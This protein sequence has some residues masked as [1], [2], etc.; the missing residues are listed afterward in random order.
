MI[1]IIFCHPWHGSFNYAMLKAIIEK[2]EYEKREYQLI[3]L[4]ADGFN[5][6]MNS[7]DLR[8][9]SRGESPDPLVNKYIAM[10]QNTDEIIFMF[11]IWWGMIPAI[12]KGFF[13]RVLLKGSSFSHSSAGEMVPKLDIS[14]CLL[15]STSQG[16]TAIYRPYIEDYFTPYILNSVGIVDVEWYNCEKTSHGPQENREE[17]LKNILSI[18]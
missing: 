18:I 10:L 16:E 13:D 5:P 11:P 6:A 17:F 9:Y 2:L 1:T 12:L 3:D 4:N 8:L 7:D 14:R 15:I